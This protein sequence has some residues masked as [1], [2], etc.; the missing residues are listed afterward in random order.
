ML[1]MLA[2]ATA[3]PAGAG[4]PLWRDY[5][6][7]GP[8]IQITDSGRYFNRPL[9]GAGNGMLVMAGDR[10]LA[11]GAASGK[12]LGTLMVA[13]SRGGRCSG[14]SQLDPSASAVH[15]YRQAGWAR[16]RTSP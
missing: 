9:Y 8:A 14:W 4:F 1:L 12:E 6:P 7:A 16:P 3:T 13:L 11:R 5:A 2:A 10:P 15:S